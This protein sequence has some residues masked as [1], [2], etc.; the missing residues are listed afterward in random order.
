MPKKIKSSLLLKIPGKQFEQEILSSD[1]SGILK[2]SLFHDFPL[3][4]KLG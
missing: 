3:N 1:F 4:I 2:F